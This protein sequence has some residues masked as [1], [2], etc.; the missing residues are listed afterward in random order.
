[1]NNSYTL[2]DKITDTIFYLVVISGL[3]ALIVLVFGYVMLAFDVH[4]A[5]AMTVAGWVLLVDVVMFIVYMWAVTKTD[6]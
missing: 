3:V 5:S 6:I 1:M 2:F 4:Y